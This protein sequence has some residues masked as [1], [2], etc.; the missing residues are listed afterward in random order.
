SSLLDHFSMR[1]AGPT[2][3][4]IVSEILS[5]LPTSMAASCSELTERSS[6]TV[7]FQKSFEYLTLI[8]N[9]LHNNGFATKN[10]NNLVIGPFEYKGI[11][12]N[13]SLQ[14]MDIPNL[15]VLILQM[16]NCI[17]QLCER[18]VAK[19]TAPQNDPHLEFMKSQLGFY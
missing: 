15:V 2:K 16:V 17:E 7:P 19:I 14:C 8:R 4:E 10:M 11:V 12:E 6:A 5:H 1:T 9:S 18:S 13:Q 3:Q